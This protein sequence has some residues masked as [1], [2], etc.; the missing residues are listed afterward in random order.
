MRIVDWISDVCSS[1]LAARILAVAGRTVRTVA[2]RNAVRRAKTAEAPAL[3]RAGKALA[4]GVAGDID[5]LP[6]NEMPG[7]D[8]GADGD[9]CVLV[10]N[11]TASCRERV[12]Q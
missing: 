6:G 2:E 12:C 8:F 10:Q 9:E 3:H 1:V 7:A 5:L 4:L 11:G